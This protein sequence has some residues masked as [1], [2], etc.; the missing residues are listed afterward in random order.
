[1]CTISIFIQNGYNSAVL[2]LLEA[3]L[4]HSYALGK[5]ARLVNVVPPQAR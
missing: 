1:M 3:I 4:L 5:V 2:G